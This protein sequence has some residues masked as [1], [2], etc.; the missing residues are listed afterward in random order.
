[1]AH[2]LK[3]ILVEEL[4]C[5]DYVAHTCLVL[6]TQE[7]ESFRSA[8]TLTNDD[9]A[10]H[11]YKSAVAHFPYVDCPQCLQ[12]FQLSAVISNRMFPNRQ[13]GAAEISVNSL[14]QRHLLQ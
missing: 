14:S 8:G 4:R 11:S 12:L 1:M 9:P 7:H 2:Q 3:S 5:D 13:A 10:G 6:E